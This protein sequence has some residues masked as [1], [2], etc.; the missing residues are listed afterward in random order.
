MSIDSPSSKVVSF[1]VLS[2]LKSIIL[3]LP[4]SWNS[5]SLTGRLCFVSSCFGLM[6]SVPTLKFLPEKAIIICPSLML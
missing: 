4:F 2:L 1:F 3:H 5:D 6:F